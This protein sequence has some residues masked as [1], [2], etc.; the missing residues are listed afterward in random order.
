MAWGPFGPTV[1]SVARTPSAVMRLRAAVREN[2]LGRGALGK[3]SVAC[4]VPS[5][6]VTALPRAT[7]IGAGEVRSTFATSASNGI[8]TTS[9][10][11]A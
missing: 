4:R 7:W 2:H 1:Y 9:G 6:S 8:R 5:P 11:Q 3:S 10:S